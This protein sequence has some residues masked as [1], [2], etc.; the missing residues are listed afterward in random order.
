MPL[1]W[2]K[3]PLSRLVFR[4]I[5]LVGLIGAAGIPTDAAIQ[6]D[7]ALHSHD[8]P[9]PGRSALDVE[10]DDFGFLWFATGGGLVRYDGDE[11][12]TYLLDYSDK[13]RLSPNSPSSLLKEPGGHVWAGNAWG[14]VRVDPE[15]DSLQWI[16]GGPERLFGIDDP[17]RKP[18]NPGQVR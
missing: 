13:T 1:A 8:D 11:S 6:S 17:A 12:R 5:V 16:V 2:R 9:I 15:S 14:I 4:M 7:V 3:T 18:A 10:Q